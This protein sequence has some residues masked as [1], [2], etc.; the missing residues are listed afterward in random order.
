[1]KILLLITV[2]ILAVG[3]GKK[4]EKQ[5]SPPDE[6]AKQKNEKRTSSPDE[7]AEQKAKILSNLLTSALRKGDIKAAKKHLDDGADVDK[8]NPLN[9]VIE[10]RYEGR[11]EI[12]KLLL[13]KGSDVNR[14]NQRGWTPAE[15]LKRTAGAMMFVGATDSQLAGNNE[16][17][18]LLIQHGA[19]TGDNF[20]YWF[21]SAEKPLEEKQK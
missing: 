6:S 2:A 1:M 13:A 17:A 4:D 20:K 3:C 19:K 18:S 8:G 15:S 21:P 5:D 14:K 9:I 12:V 11:A 10:A 7:S 16:I